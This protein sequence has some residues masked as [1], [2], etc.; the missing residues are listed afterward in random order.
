MKKKILQALIEANYLGINSTQSD[1]E[2]SFWRNGIEH[3]FIINMEENYKLMEYM[4]DNDLYSG[5]FGYKIVYEHDEVEYIIA[6][7][8]EL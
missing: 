6:Y 5:D 1:I 7:L 8:D 4:D 2:V 3:S